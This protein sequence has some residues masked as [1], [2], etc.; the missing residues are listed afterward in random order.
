MDFA[1][2]KETRSEE[3]RS[4]DKIWGPDGTLPDFRDCAKKRTASKIEAESLGFALRQG[5]SYLLLRPLNRAPVSTVFHFLKL[6]HE[7]SRR[8]M[9]LTRFEPAPVIS[10]GCCAAP[11]L[12]RGRCCLCDRR[13]Q[14]LPRNSKNTTC[15]RKAPLWRA[16]GGQKCPPSTIA[17]AWVT[18]S[19]GLGRVVAERLDAEGLSGRCACSRGG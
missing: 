7:E 9:N 14:I 8:G 6:P 13:A 3:T 11:K 4:E 1:R 17:V 12:R 18:P 2:L 15:K 19:G 5:Q 10:T 16:D